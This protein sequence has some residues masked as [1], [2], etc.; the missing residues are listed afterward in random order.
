MIS[1]PHLESLSIFTYQGVYMRGTLPM[2]MQQ[3]A[4][5]V[6]QKLKKLRL[7]MW[8]PSDLVHWMLQVQSSGC[9]LETLD[10]VV[11]NNTTT[12]WGLVEALEW[13]LVAN[14]NTLEQLSIG[15]QY[16]LK[17]HHGWESKGV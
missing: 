1:L 9:K 8:N 4:Q 16:N 3:Q 15:V 10:V 11:F 13:F 17:K 12:G 2:P 7:R 14:S 6:L 5:G